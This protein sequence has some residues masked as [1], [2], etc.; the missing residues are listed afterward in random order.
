M[1]VPFSICVHDQWILHH[2]VSVGTS[3]WFQ[4]CL[5]RVAPFSIPGRSTSRRSFLFFPLSYRAF[6]INIGGSAE[7]RFDLLGIKS[8]PGL[9]NCGGKGKLTENKTR[10]ALMVHNFL[11][12]KEQKHYAHVL[13][14]VDLSLIF[15][16]ARKR[17]K[18]EN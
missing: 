5:S 13:M 14:G 8:G 18:T 7:T 4:S 2:F 17:A 9:K 10:S 15:A 12:Y 6:G 11:H 16:T 1:P 3:D